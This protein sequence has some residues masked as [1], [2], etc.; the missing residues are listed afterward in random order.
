VLSWEEISIAPGA[1]TML[2]QLANTVARQNGLGAST[3]RAG[4]RFS[5]PSVRGRGVQ[6]QVAL[7][8][9]V[10]GADHVSVRHT[11]VSDPDVDLG[12]LGSGPSVEDQAGD[13]CY[14]H[15]VS[16]RNRLSG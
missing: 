13:S 1:G 3:V 4:C 14:G 10:R 15:L 2:A 16:W 5:T 7:C 8:S 11:G 6:S 12:R 9:H